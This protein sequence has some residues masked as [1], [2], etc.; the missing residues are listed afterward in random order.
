MKKELTLQS[1]H[2]KR[3]KIYSKIIKDYPFYLLLLPS[4]IYVLVFSYVP[5]P[6]II[7]AF[8][9]YD[10]FKGIWGSPWVGLENIRK[11][12]SLYSFSSAIV[13]TVVVNV[14]Q[15][16][17]NFPAPIILA[18]LINEIRNMFF[19]RVVQTISYLPHFLSTIAVV[20]LVFMLF[21]RYGL[22]N[23]FR[24]MLGMERTVLFAQQKNFILF[25]VLVPLWQGLGW[26]TIIHLANLSSINPELY[27]AAQIDGGN[28]WKQTWY[29]TIPH[30]IPTV[31]LLLIFQMGGMF[32]SSLDLVYGLQNPYVDFENISTV[33][34]KTGIQRGNYEMGTALGFVQSLIALALTACANSIAK[35]VSGIAIW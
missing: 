7:L 3:N 10:M 1:T 25:L 27:E 19:K 34:Y 11:I 24:E 12:F 2:R 17:I 15:L 26:G 30:M 28:R 33:V 6:G 13:N 18:L 16:I 32:S 29:I 21:N 22:V 14:L 4:I 35:K 9:D 20:G 5:M 31:I 8:K 23:D